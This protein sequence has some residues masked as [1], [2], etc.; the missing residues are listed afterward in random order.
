MCVRKEGR[1]CIQDLYDPE[2]YAFG[3][4][5]KAT[6]GLRLQSYR[7]PTKDGLESTWVG[8]EHYSA[9]PGVIAGGIVATLVETQGNWTAA[10]ALMDRDALRAPPLTATQN[11]SVNFRKPVPTNEEV[12]VT[13]TYKHLAP[14]PNKPNVQKVHVKVEI[15]AADPLPSLSGEEKRIL[16]AAGEATFVKIGAMRDLRSGDF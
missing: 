5:P 6:V 14:T 4:G 15:H 10:V 1:L 3:G 7:K 8:G 11:L 12:Y 16:C 2:S 9:F 13:S